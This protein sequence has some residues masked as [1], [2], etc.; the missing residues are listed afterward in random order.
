MRERTTKSSAGHRIN[1]GWIVLGIF[2][3][4]MVPVLLF[5]GIFVG[6]L[7]DAESCELNHHQVYDQEYRTAHPEY[8]NRNLFP[9]SNKCNASYDMVPFWMNPAIVGFALLSVGAFTVPPLR[10]RFAGEHTD[11]RR[12][13]AL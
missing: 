10:N 13:A 12:S 6:G 3:A 4:F 5:F 8:A 1:P 7:D 9:L 11:S 2:S